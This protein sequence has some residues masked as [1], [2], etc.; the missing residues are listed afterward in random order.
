M[1][2][3]IYVLFLVTLFL[4]TYIHVQDNYLLNSTFIIYVLKASALGTVIL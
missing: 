3:S 1:L 4:Y 2:Q